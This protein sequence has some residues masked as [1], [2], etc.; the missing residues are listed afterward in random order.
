MRLVMAGAGPFG[1]L[2]WAE[3]LVAAQPHSS[4]RAPPGSPPSR[5]AI[6]LSLFPLKHFNLVRGI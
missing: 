5:A 6:S 4:F 1:Q 3:L 2:P